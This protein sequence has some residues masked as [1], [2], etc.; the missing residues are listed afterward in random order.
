MFEAALY[1][2]VQAEVISTSGWPNVTKEEDFLPIIFMQHTD[3]TTTDS[4]CD[5]P[6]SLEYRIIYQDVLAEPGPGRAVHQVVGASARLHYQTLHLSNNISS[7]AHLLTSSAVFAQHSKPSKLSRFWE[8]M[9]DRWCERETC[10]REILWPWTHGFSRR[11]WVGDIY[12]S[13]FLADFLAQS[14]LGLALFFPPLVVTLTQ[15]YR[16][17]W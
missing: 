16:L 13:G 14:L 5:V 3:N 4:G 8:A 12:E 10:W 17:V 15:G 2:L 11:E 7:G 6:S 9:E 1:S